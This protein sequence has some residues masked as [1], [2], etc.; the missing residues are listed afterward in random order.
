MSE[1]WIINDAYFGKIKN[2]SISGEAV[3]QFINN[4]VYKQPNWDILLGNLLEIYMY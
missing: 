2:V 3:K 1:D 4:V